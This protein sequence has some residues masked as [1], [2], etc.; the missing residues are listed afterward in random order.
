[1]KNIGLPGMLM[2]VLTLLC[3]LLVLWGLRKALTKTGWSEAAQRSVFTGTVLVIT[4]WLVLLSVLS[5]AGF[6]RHFT[7]LPPRVALAILAPAV[8]LVIIS[9]RKRCIELL[10]AAPPHWLVMLQ[11]FRVAVE[12][13]LWL[14]FTRGLI[15]VQM[16]FEGRNYDIISGLLGLLAGWLMWRFKLY[17]KIISIIYNV[18][19]LTLLLNI[20]VIAVLSIP[21]PTRYFMNEPANTI[22]AEFPFIFLPG[23]LVVLAIALHVFSLRQVFLKHGAP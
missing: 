15:P 21:G 1:M 10:R 8:L 11:G 13:Q 3:V 12:I 20:L 5:L 6:F 2:I 18:I 16:T 22:V 14:A 4:G 23:G 17:Q 19:G 9:F 7:A